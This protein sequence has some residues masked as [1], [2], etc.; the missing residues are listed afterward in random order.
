[1]PKSI[2]TLP[3]SSLV[4]SSTR[5]FAYSALRSGTEQPSVITESGTSGAV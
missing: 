5:E 3:R 2:A 4:K 1:M